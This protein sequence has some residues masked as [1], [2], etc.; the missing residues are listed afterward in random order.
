MKTVK[1]LI[2]AGGRGTRISEESGLRPKPM[3]EIGGMPILWHIM[4]HYSGF[5]HNEFIICC[6][7]KGYMIKEYFANYC[8]H[9]SDVT[10]D[11]TGGN[12]MQ[13]HGN[14]NEPWKVTLVD[15]GIDTMTGGRIKRVE[16]YTEGKRFMITYGDG[17]SDVDINKMLKFHEESE[18]T[19]TLTAVRPQARFGS[20]DFEKDGKTAVFA[21][22]GARQADW[23][24]GGFMAAEPHIFRH[25]KD[26]CSVFEKDVLEK[27]SAEKKLAAF[28]HEGF[29]QCMDTLRDK[30]LL[31]G[32]IEKGEA[33]WVKW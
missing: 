13:I 20:V 28:K 4:K 31:D 26:D 14:V 24:N 6:G 16:E 19:V 1:T 29:W 8:L 22:K 18:K 12:K 27:L 23:I 25:L 2:L 15:T 30:I 3:I 5:G 33:P 32:M 17:V 21:E 7:Y 11:F 9:R 10:F